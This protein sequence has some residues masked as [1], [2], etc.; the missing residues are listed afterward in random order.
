MTPRDELDKLLGDTH[1]TPH[2]GDEWL[3]QHGPAVLALIE[4]VDGYFA[5]AQGRP[6]AE[7]RNRMRAAML[8][9]NPDW[10]EDYD[11]S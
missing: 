7:N 1:H 5:S 2:H 3:R 6:L 8:R 9:L 10:E 4:A 11:P